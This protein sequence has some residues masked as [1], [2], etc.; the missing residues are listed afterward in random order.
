MSFV[1]SLIRVI[2]A[3]VRANR[4]EKIGIIPDCHLRAVDYERSQINA[5]SVL[6]DKLTLWN[7][8]LLGYSAS[9]VSVPLHQFAHPFLQFAAICLQS[10]MFDHND[11]SRGGSGR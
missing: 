6:V 9:P 10:L 4:F 7:Y 2:E 11:V 5:L 3:S 1:R 8:D